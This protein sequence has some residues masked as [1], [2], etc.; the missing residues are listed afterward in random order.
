[1]TTELK[2]RLERIDGNLVF[3]AAAE[4]KLPRPTCAQLIEFLTSRGY[5]WAQVDKATMARWRRRIEAERAS[6]AG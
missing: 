3:V 6:L 2:E 4:E 5:R 1:M